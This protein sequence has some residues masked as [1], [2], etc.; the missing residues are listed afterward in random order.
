MSKKK[1]KQKSL[2]AKLAK[3]TLNENPNRA[4]STKICLKLIFG[5]TFLQ[6]VLV[7]LTL[8]LSLN[9]FLKSSFNFDPIR[10]LGETMYTEGKVVEINNLGFSVNDRDMF[11][12]DYQI[13]VDGKVYSGQSYLTGWLP[14]DK[15]LEVEY[16]KGKPEVSRAVDGSRGFYSFRSTMIFVSLLAILALLLRNEIRRVFLL[17]FG[18][19]T[20]LTFMGLKTHGSDGSFSYTHKYKFKTVEGVLTT[21]TYKSERRGRGEADKIVFHLKSK[22]K[23]NHTL[24]YFEDRGVAFNHTKEELDL[25]KSSGSTVGL[26]FPLIFCAEVIYLV[27][28]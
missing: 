19:K 3:M 1:K 28:N 21:G 15:K 4:L 6:L 18:V 2:D 24:R 25:K 26:I 9:L 8:M 20:P 13:A 12:V 17:K 23:I 5:S 7:A 22:P 10:F 14:R 11:T 27:M 16:I